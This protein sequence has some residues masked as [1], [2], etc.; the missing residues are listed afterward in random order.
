MEKTPYEPLHKSKQAS[1][2]LTP[3]GLVY[4]VQWWGRWPGRDQMVPAIRSFR[5]SDPLTQESPLPRE[6][7]L[8]G[9]SPPADPQIDS[10]AQHQAPKSAAAPPSQPATDASS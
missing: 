5:S 10:P 4:S 7:H 3:A 1:L 2:L 8:T 9:V 6:H